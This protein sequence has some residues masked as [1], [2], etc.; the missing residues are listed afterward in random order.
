MYALGI[1]LPIRAT[2]DPVGWGTMGMKRRTDRSAS[3]CLLTACVLGL[4]SSAGAAPIKSIFI[5]VTRANPTPL[6]FAYDGGTGQGELTIT[7]DSFTLLV[8]R[9]EGGVDVPEFHIGSS[10]Q[11]TATAFADHSSPP[12]AAGEF[13]SIEFELIDAENNLLLAGSQVG[14]TGLSYSEAV[15]PDLMFINGGEVEITGGVFDTDFAGPAHLFGIGIGIA[16]G[17]DSFGRLDTSHTGAVKLNLYPIP[18]PASLLI[19]TLLAG[20]WGRRRVVAKRP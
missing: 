19:W 15:I 8:T 14:G 2:N 18:E 1:R 3:V 5:D 20:C 12:L 17:T 6:E 10:F 9:N 11:M 4:C 13:S 16:P 7:L